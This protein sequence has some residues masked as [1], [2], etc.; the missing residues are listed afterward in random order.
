MHKVKT[1]LKVTLLL[2]SI[3]AAAAPGKEEFQAL[4]DQ[5]SES[6][7]AGR[8]SEAITAYQTAYKVKQLPKLLLMIGKSQLKLGAVADAKHSFQ[9][10]L[11]VKPDAVENEEVQRLIQQCQKMLA[12]P[13]IDDAAVGSLPMVA[14][15]EKS[16]MKPLESNRDGV[17]T[18]SS[19]M[20]SV[21][22]QSPANREE[23]ANGIGPPSSPLSSGTSTRSHQ[24]VMGPGS[25]TSLAVSGVLGVASIGLGFSA[26][27]HARAARSMA[28]RI[29]SEQQALSDAS[30]V[31][32]QS[33][34]AIVIGAVSAV[35]LVT[36][37]TVIGVRS[38]RYAKV[39]VVVPS[40]DGKA[41]A[42]TL[43]SRF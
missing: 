29:E 12:P 4:Y 2:C 7:L 23:Q 30:S 16:S 15:A 40:S 19:G 24:F 32:N 22:E 26:E 37:L 20:S 41:A 39:P 25:W 8:Y 1:F 38:R 9:W 33:A 18:S 5:A 21:E 14:D 36:T 31:Q 17:T 28:Y 34:S 6:Y 35:A 10:F 42:L 3:N 13:K 11:E 43:T 27:G